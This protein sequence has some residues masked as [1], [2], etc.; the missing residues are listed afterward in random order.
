[1]SSFHPKLRDFC[2]QSESRFGFC[3]FSGRLYSLR[4]ET[5]QNPIGL[6]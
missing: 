3:T 1:M 5:W 4:S 6:I 2:R